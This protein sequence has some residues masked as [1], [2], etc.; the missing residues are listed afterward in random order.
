MRIATGEETETL[1]ADDGEDPAAKA[2]GKKGGAA[3]AKSMT[4]E[5]RAQIAKKAAFLLF[6]EIAACL[7]TQTHARSKSGETYGRLWSRIA[8][9]RRRKRRATHVTRARQPGAL[10]SSG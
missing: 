1:T 5:R 8:R 10:S 4:P 9:R 7:A 2:L 3:R 6:L